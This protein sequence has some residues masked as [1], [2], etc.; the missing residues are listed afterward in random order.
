MYII[1]EKINGTRKS[2]GK[3]I[4]E[5]N[6]AFIQELAL[7]QVEGGAS[8]LDVNA[9]TRPDQEPDDLLWLV[10]LV[11]DV[12]DVPLCLDSA[13][14]EA[15]RYVMPA[16][17]QTPMINSISGEP[18][19]L[20]GILPVVAEFNCPVIA[21]CMDDK[22]IPADKEGRMDVIRKVFEETRKVGVPDN[23]MYV[24]PLAMTI[25]TNTNS[26]NIIFDTMRQI[27]AEFPEAHISCGLSNVSFGLPARS[28]INRTFMALALDA[29][30]DAALINPNDRELISA[31]YA[32]ELLL[33]K[34]RHCLKYTRAFR[35]GKIGPVE[36]K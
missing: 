1:G 30:M 34:D 24:D 9:G 12:T 17:K 28:L 20:Q 32:T 26:G 31:I 29:G 25:A 14:P 33:G 35:A 7:K 2:V 22:G 19:R 3:A 4:A 11:Q 5:R 27:R 10:N 8:W 13:N 36:T 21:L 16:V 6:A 18:D 23:N 15:L